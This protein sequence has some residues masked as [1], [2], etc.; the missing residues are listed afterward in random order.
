MRKTGQFWQAHPHVATPIKTPLTR[1]SLSFVLGDRMA[2]LRTILDF[3]LRRAAAQFAAIERPLTGSDIEEIV[4]RFPGAALYV[5]ESGELQQA[6]NAAALLVLALIDDRVDRVVRERLQALIL[7][8]ASGRP[9]VDRFSV[10]HPDDPAS[11]KRIF[12]ITFVPVPRGV[13]MLAQESTLERNLITALTQ[14]R[15]L[16]RDLVNLSSAFAW[17]TDEKGAFTFVSKTGAVG[18]S[19]QALHGRLADS[20]VVSGD[21][22]EAMPSIL[23]FYARNSVE[24]VEVWM[25]AADGGSR[26]FLVSASPII[27]ETGVRRGARGV[28]HDIT[29]ERR[30]EG[31]LHRIQARESLSRAVVDAI[32]RHVEPA[33]M[34]SASAHAVRLAAHAD[35]CWIIE[36]KEGAGWSVLASDGEEG[37]SAPLP[38]EALKSLADHHVFQDVP[39]DFASAQELGL[40]ITTSY[41]GSTNG[42]IV[43]A[44]G[45]LSGSFDSD[46]SILLH[47]IAPHLGVALAHAR[48]VRTLEEQ[49]LTDTL[50]GLMNR[51]AFLRE[52][53]R[54][55]EQHRRMGRK[56]VLIYADLDD[57]KQVNDDG[58]HAA[59]DAAIKA[60]GVIL[61]KRL[62]AGD[63]SVR[64]GGDEFGIW[65][66]EADA[67][68]AELK[69]A[70]L[71]E[72]VYEAGKTLGTPVPL[73]L[74]L[75]AAV[76]EPS[77]RESLADLMARADVALY[78][79]KRAGKRRLRIAEPAR[80]EASA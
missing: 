54:R 73:S 18:Y 58:G 17:E 67:V 9:V 63:L 49:A 47:S 66:E 20:L 12:D 22:D 46:S 31:E 26:C 69:A 53:G 5:R 23:P 48:L 77:S 34:L 16:F 2:S 50:T 11:A 39:H 38:N 59:G 40:V 52:A 44:R 56:A 10:A 4:A 70:E 25:R 79:A 15:E 27:D 42:A 24:D 71:Q 64:F 55:L 68:V 19:P 76:F 80:M 29:N 7:R 3:P 57:F 35:R 30:R 14:S 72:H 8:C 21:D 75:G 37:S 61:H 45:A 1:L 62:R 74:S 36:P 41:Q 28:S 78:A 33:S 65:L 32:H 13:L 60:I 43:I 6:N 51:R